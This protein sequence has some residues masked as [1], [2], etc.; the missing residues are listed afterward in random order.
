EKVP[1]FAKRGRKDEALAQ[2][3]R[4]DGVPADQLVFLEDG[5]A[6]LENMRTQLAAL[7]K[8]ARPGSTFIFYFQGHGMREFDQDGK[9]YLANYDV[10]VNDPF[11][12]AFHVS[13]IAKTLDDDWRGKRLL[14]LGDC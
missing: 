11:H 14:L 3:F 2:Q 5:E 7:A 13:E 10:D 9:S 6:T 8:K 1:A 12:T 4:D